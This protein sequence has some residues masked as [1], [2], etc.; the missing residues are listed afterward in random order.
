MTFVEHNNREKANKFAEYVTGK[1]LREYL[2]NKVKQYCGKNISVFDGA[3]GS[4]QLEQFISMT[5]FHAVEIQQ[6]SCEA[7][8]TNFPNVVVN[9]QSFF[10]YQSDIQV[11][12]IA[13][14][15]PYSLK[16]KDLPEEDQQA[17]KELYPWKKSGVVDDIF[18]LKSMNYTKRYG[19]Y[20]MFP[21][22]A[23]RQSEKKMR[24]LVGNNLV[25][26]NVIQNGFEDTS[27]N[28]IFLVIDK[29]KNSPEISK[30][31]YDCKTKKVEYEESDTLDSDFRWVAPSKPVEKEE[32]DIDQ[33][34][35]ELDQMAINHLEKHLASQLILI[36]FFNADIDLKSFITK[37]HKV[38]DDYLLMYNFAVDR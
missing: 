11:D 27:I 36:Q 38:L 12:A 26:L 24:E 34:N 10:T 19:F 1:P 28:V 20:I 37:C 8:K 22:I 23:Y 31:I 9:N 17:I 29:E 7:L 6:E 4:G 35:A 13:M 30:E 32:I 25:E 2:A 16:L 21:G 14:N 33:V 18:L 15:P 5:D 3:A